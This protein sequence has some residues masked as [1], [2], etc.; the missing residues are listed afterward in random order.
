VKTA[1]VGPN[2][3]L[4]ARD[5]GHGSFDIVFSDDVAGARTDLEGLAMAYD[6]NRDGVL[7]ALDTEFASFGVWQDANSNGLVDANE[8]HSLTEAGI[9]SVNLV[10]DGQ[11]YLA[12]GGDVVVYGT[13]SFAKADGTSGVLADASFSTE[14][15]AEMNL[16]GG[17]V[18]TVNAALAA[19]VMP[20]MLVAMNWDKSGLA[21]EASTLGNDE[22]VLGSSHST[23]ALPD[24]MAISGDDFLQL[25]NSG[26]G[27]ASSQSTGRSHTENISIDE[28]SEPVMFDHANLVLPD[29]T[30]PVFSFGSGSGVS[31][32]VAPSVEGMHLMDA[33]LTLGQD[34]AIEVQSSAAEGGTGL[35]LDAS[36]LKEAMADINDN[37]AIDAIVDHFSGDIALGAAEPVSH[38]DTGILDVGIA[39]AQATF[40]MPSMAELT[41]DDMSALAASA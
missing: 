5:I 7:D 2:D 9:L 31:E 21:P 38:F 13:G 12:E 35:N 23:I 41:A 22:L 16:R 40:G 20:E 34:V 19:L 25:S 27:P 3:G 14:E 6:S 4:L 1:W 8:F 29:S 18:A 10:S 30:G 39:D 32:F 15:I 36:A 28:F 37:H 24:Q 17:Q 11:G 26:Q 33:L